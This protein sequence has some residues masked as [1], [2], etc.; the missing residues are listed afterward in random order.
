MQDEERVVHVMA[1]ILGSEDARGV[2]DEACSAQLDMKWE[3]DVEQDTEEIKVCAT[4]EAAS[5]CSPSSKSNY[6]EHEREHG[7]RVRSVSN[8]SQIQGSKLV[9][10]CCR[11][12]KLLQLF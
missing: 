2:V 12:L 5:Q 8:V 6:H 10:S 4:S 7:A 11:R 1:L 3:R 9:K